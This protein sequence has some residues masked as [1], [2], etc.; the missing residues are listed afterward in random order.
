M[1]PEPTT[2]YTKKISSFIYYSKLPPNLK[3]YLTVICISSYIFFVCK[4]FK[5]CHIAWPSLMLKS[6]PTFLSRHDHMSARVL[7]FFVTCSKVHRFYEEKSKK[8]KNK[9]WAVS[10]SNWIKRLP[11]LNFTVILTQWYMTT[12]IYI[13]ISRRCLF[14]FFLHKYTFIIILV[15]FHNDSCLD[16]FFVFLRLWVKKIRFLKIWD[17]YF[18]DS[19]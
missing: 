13:Y 3:V 15:F 10:N 6:M 14:I 17:I 16:H 9:N 11:W 2:I 8:K 5:N 12:L 19:L 1:V 18:F 4:L 7:Q